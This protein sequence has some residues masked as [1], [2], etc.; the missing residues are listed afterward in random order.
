MGM[1]IIR[2][3]IVRKVLETRVCVVDDEEIVLKC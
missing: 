1:A 2:L 3:M